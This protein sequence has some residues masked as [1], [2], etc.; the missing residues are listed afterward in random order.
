M[1]GRPA[2]LKLSLMVIGTPNSGALRSLLLVE[3]AGTRAGAVEVAHHDGV[4]ARIEAFD[5]GDVV[6]EQFEAADVARTQHGGEA[7]GGE[8]GWVHRGGLGVGGSRLAQQWV[9]AIIGSQGAHGLG[10]CTAT[11]TGA[12]ATYCCDRA[13]RG[14]A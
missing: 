11:N 9:G 7:G 12:C 14:L 4:D 13:A 8:E 6:V 1:V 10:S 2:T 5:A 3:G